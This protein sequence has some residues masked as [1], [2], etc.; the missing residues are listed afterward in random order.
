[1]TRNKLLSGIKED[2]WAVIVLVISFIYFF[3]IV[4]LSK[5]LYGDADSISHY[6]RAH[7]AFKYP[8]LFVDHW[9]K[10]LY[11]T[12][13]APFAQFGYYGA[14][15]FNILCGLVTAWLIYRIAKELKMRKPVAVIPFALFSPIYMIT[16]MT[17][18]TEILFSL[19]LVAGIF[20]FMKQKS[21]TSAIVISFIPFARTEGL[22]FLPIF[23]L[24]FLLK[25]QYKAIPFLVTGLILISFAGY[26][27]YKDI[28]WFFNEN[29]YGSQGSQLYGS[30]SFY[31]YIKN[32]KHLL[33]WPLT[34]LATI[35]LAGF[36]IGLKK[37]NKPDLTYTWIT[38]NYLVTGSFILYLLLQSFL[39]WQGLLG[40]LGSFRFMACI[41][42]LAGILALNGIN[43]GFDFIKEKN[44]I[45]NIILLTAIGFVVVIPYKVY[46]IPARLTGSYQ[47]MKETADAL[48]KLGFENKRIIFFDPKLAFYLDADRF[49]E[50]RFRSSIYDP[51]TPEIKM[52]DSSYM[53]WDTHGGGFEKKI[54]LNELLR[55][56]NFKLI[57]G[58][59]PDHEYRF[60]ATGLNYMSL[61]FQKLTVQYP[62]NEWIRLDSVDF[63]STTDQNK[64][65]A[66]TDSVSFTGKRSFKLNS[67][68]QYSLAFSKT[69]NEISSSKKVIYRSRVA[70]MVPGGSDA[71]KLLLVFEVRD[72]KE[73]IFRY[74]VIDASYFKPKP[75]EWFEMTLIAPLY[76]DFPE[77]GFIKY[78]LVN[79]GK[80]TY[81]VDDLIVEYLTVNN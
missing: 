43:F 45:Q 53:V 7:Y 46:E 69:L 81:Y 57:D 6:Q 21:I 40:V 68:F 80:G 52:P 41:M 64:L 78:Y 2:G 44:W 13:S 54:D 37:S 28:F 63:E 34:V 62:V 47:V 60:G 19:V 38:K 55:N 48:K 9:G 79:T 74:V 65:E 32:Y 3:T 20:F 11:T 70:A 73:G 59:V 15:C 61:I 71:S 77:G 16:M 75:G 18:L 12:L 33:G 10:P 22:M 27:H 67:E 24:A 5:G 31:F 26:F 29:P 76:T 50:K 39:W 36:I 4:V 72:S 23:L 49:D 17:G 14:L 25:K 58:F 1:M 30:G 35:G 56:P 66:L 8:K 51:H 42:P